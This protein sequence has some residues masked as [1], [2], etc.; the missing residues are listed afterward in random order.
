[1]GPCQEWGRKQIKTKY[2]RKSEKLAFLR[3]HPNECPAYDTKQTDGEASVM[4][5]IWGMQSTTSLQ[6]LPAPLWLGVVARDRVLSLDQIEQL[7][8]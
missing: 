6:S 2:S 7:D 5:E 3:L 8:I 4:P 1:M